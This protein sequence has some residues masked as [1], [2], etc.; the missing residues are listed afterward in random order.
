MF[1]IG[2]KYRIREGEEKKYLLS[3]SN[4]N[5]S[6]NAVIST[7]EFIV[8]DMK[9]NNVTMISTA[10]SRNAGKIL[11][12]L[13]SEVLIYDEEFDFFEEV[14]ENFDFECTITMK[15]GDPLSFTVKDEGSRLRII[16]LLQAIKFK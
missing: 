13:R 1:K 3:A 9:G 6:I 16:S 15:S 7:S 5:G 14:S 10:T 12:S 8:E 4:R 11:H 2:K